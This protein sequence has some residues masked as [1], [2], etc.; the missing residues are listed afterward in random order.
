MKDFFV[1]VHELTN[2][3][4]KFHS[5][6]FCTRVATVMPSYREAQNWLRLKR[7]LLEVIQ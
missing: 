1:V 7:E 5:A 6:K 3:T 4:I 2:I